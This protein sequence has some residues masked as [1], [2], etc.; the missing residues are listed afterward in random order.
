MAE[1]T[2]IADG[3]ALLDSVDR[4]A[5]IFEKVGSKD[6]AVECFGD[7]SWAADLRK[8]VSKQRAL[9]RETGNIGHTADP[10]LIL[11]LRLE[12]MVRENAQTDPEL[13]AALRIQLRAIYEQGIALNAA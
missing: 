2:K 10:A 5:A 4:T 1:G 12:G 3:E 7:L 9:L 8:L 6:W 13:S 11:R